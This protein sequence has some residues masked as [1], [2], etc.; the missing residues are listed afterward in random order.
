MK[1]SNQIGSA[2]VAII[3]VLVVALLGALGYIFYQNFIQKNSPDSS[4]TATSNAAASL[5][6]QQKAIAK[7]EVV[8]E[9]KYLILD[10]WGVRFKLPQDGVSVLYKKTTGN[11][12][13]TYGFNTQAV[14]ALGGYCTLDKASGGLAAVTRES[15]KLVDYA[16]MKPLNNNEPIGGYYYYMS[17]SQA[18]CSDS[19]QALEMSERQ[20]L[21]NMLETIE[22][23]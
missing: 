14:D 13:V 5:P 1:K 6:E 12:M 17:G 4:K 8:D 16:S 7:P 20:K 19:N 22:S 3:G 23:K 9:A 18:P 15:A 10:D 11:G 21:M 2:H